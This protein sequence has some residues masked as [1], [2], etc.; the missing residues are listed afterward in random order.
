[1]IANNSNFRPGVDLFVRV[2]QNTIG[3]I[4][5]PGPIFLDDLSL[6]SGEFLKDLQNGKKG[7][8]KLT[9]RYIEISGFPKI[10]SALR[11]RAVPP[12]QF[13][14]EGGPVFSTKKVNLLLEKA[15]R[16]VIRHLVM[17]G[18]PRSEKRTS[19]FSSYDQ[20]RDLECR[21]YI[22]PKGTIEPKV[23]LEVDTCGKWPNR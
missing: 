4:S 14:I 18:Y 6:F 16:I 15:I 19:T 9:S 11:K 12:V 23:I 21:I 3:R 2:L 22:H 5:G 17:N 8:T 7:L 20:E 13:N 1:M 10:A